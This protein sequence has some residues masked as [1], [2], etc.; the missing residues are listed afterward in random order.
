[1]IIYQPFCVAFTSKLLNF[2][3]YVLPTNTHMVNV[4][5][6]AKSLKL[7]RGK[8]VDTL[9]NHASK[10]MVQFPVQAENTWDGK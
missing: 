3:I 7:N 1:M 2:P 10:A 8:N 4:D 5:K 6:V 9:V